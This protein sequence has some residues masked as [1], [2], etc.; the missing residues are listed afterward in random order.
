MKTG[1]ILKKTINGGYSVGYWFD[2]KFIPLNKINGFCEKI[3]KTT[4]IPF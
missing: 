4:K 3:K 2:D 1:N